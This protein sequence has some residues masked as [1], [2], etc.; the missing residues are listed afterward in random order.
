[1]PCTEER[2][3]K[4]TEEG[5]LLQIRKRSL[6]RTQ[7]Y[8]HPDLISRTVRKLISLYKLASLWYFVIVPSATEDRGHVALILGFL[9]YSFLVKYPF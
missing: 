7:P 5:G 6:I 4:H 1:M 9:F 8:W 3:Y 2:P